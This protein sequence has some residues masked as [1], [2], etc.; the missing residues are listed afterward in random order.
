MAGAVGTTLTKNNQCWGLLV[1]Q[2]AFVK[3]DR[4][5]VANNESFY[6]TRAM[7]GSWKKAKFE[8]ENKPTNAKTETANYKINCH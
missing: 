4:A 5:D 2:S 1:Y 7:S 8:E 3:K 6:F